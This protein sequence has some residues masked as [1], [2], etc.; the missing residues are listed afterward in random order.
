MICKIHGTLESI[1][2]GRAHVATGDGLTWEILLPAFAAT[3]LAASTGQPVTLHT[4]QYLEGSS[5]SANLVPRIAG[6]LSPE[7]RAFFELLT[8]VKGLGMRKVL[9]AM[10]LNSGQI[11]AAIADRDVKTLQALP[12]IGRR[13]AETVVA[14]LHGRVDRFV[15]ADAYG[16][17][18]AGGEAPSEGAKAPSRAVAR[19]A[20]EVLMQLGEPRAQAIQWIDEV[21][22]RQPDLDDSQQ[23]ITEVLRH[24][25]GV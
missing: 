10:T 2:D 3:R 12:E 8:S 4:L 21:M 11:A 15:S 7:D 19:E 20:L 25:A 14:S 24:K 16:A 5:Q 22:T 17:G 18:Q 1:Q 6:F 9:R 13:T 23:I